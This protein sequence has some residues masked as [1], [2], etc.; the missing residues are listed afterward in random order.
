MIPT[1][2][3]L[4]S[5][6]PILCAAALVTTALLSA[7]APTPAPTPTPTPAFS[8]EEEAFAAAEATYR[9]YN[10]ALNQV[11]LSDPETFGATYAFSSGGFRASDKENFSEMHAK[12]YAIEGD[13]VVTKFIGTGVNRLRD[14]IN[15][16]ICV[17]VSDVLVLDEFGASVVNPD[18][19]DVYAI[20]ATFVVDSDRPLIDQAARTEDDACAS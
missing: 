16:T 4:L 1:T 11:D 10:D 5:R 15:A 18:R 3:P 12:G 6:V 14:R 9:A 17:D 8:S 13:A 19:P 7:C 2:T 20:E